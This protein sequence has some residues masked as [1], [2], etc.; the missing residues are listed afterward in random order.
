MPVNIT[1]DDQGS[2]PRTG[3]TI[4]YAPPVGIG[5]NLGQLCNGCA[6]QPNPN[7]VLNRTWHD[8]TY[9]ADTPSQTTPLTATFKFSGTGLY[10]FG[11]IPL[12]GFNPISGADYLF[13]LDEQMV[14]EYTHDPATGG[15]PSR[16]IY[17]QAL[18][19][20]S[21]IPDGDHTFRFQNG[22]EG[23]IPSLILL[24][25]LVY[26]TDDDPSSL[27]SA[28]ASKTDKITVLSSPSPVTVTVTSLS[29]VF[30]SIQSSPSSGGGVLSP[31]SPTTTPAFSTSLMNAPTNVTSGV[32]SQ[33]KSSLS[34]SVTS[35][36]E[37][38]EITSSSSFT[39]ATNAAYSPPDVVSDVS[40]RS[41]L[42]SHTRTIVIS[43]AIIIPCVIALMSIL[44]CLRRR[45]QRGNRLAYQ[46]QGESSIKHLSS[47]SHSMNEPGEAAAS[48]PMTLPESPTRRDMGEI[49]AA[50][51]RSDAVV[52]PSALPTQ[53]VD[54]APMT[55]PARPE[56][57]DIPSLPHTATH[58]YTSISERDLDATSPPAYE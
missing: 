24:D 21:S 10:V 54:D 26:T 23:G 37:S 48:A 32:S 46:V 42:S 3:E 36:G 2:D 52:Q 51:P 22:V 15:T 56:K 8:G 6:T 45:R 40:S 35:S 38:V 57:S 47:P 27:P 49:V 55:A 9:N 43:V 50:T 13:F 58:A 7:E 29:S 17:N 39:T 11:I 28:P 25:Y 53:P 12:V 14:G 1:V 44:L 4:I 41:S 34:Q 33:T 16:L 18:Y 31:L 20:N 19:S 30:A 5:W